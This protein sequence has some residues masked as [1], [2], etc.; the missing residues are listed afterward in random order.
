ML[1]KV[2]PYNFN[3]IAKTQSKNQKSYNPNLYPILPAG[4]V[5]DKEKVSFKGIHDYGNVLPQH[6]A[7]HEK[8]IEQREDETVPVLDSL[9]KGIWNFPGNVVKAITGWKQE[10]GDTTPIRPADI[11]NQAEIEDTTI[12]LE[13]LNLIA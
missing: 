7:L 3:N 6:S 13:R 12:I 4:M 8:Y 1:S 5:T 10:A 11:P 9:A 2:E